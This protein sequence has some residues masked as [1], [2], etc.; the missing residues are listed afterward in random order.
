MTQDEQIL[1]LLRAVAEAMVCEK[2]GG[3]GIYTEYRPPYKP[4][5]IIPLGPGHSVP[6]MFSSIC[7]CRV[8]VRTLLVKD[9]V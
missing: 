2:C 4:G 1:Q 3:T 7:S 5:Q 9:R 8:A 6:A